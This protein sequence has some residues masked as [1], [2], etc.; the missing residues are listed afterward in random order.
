MALQ[1]IRV[2]QISGE[3]YEREGEHWP[4]HTLRQQ[5]SL[6][7]CST[8]Q[9]FLNSGKFLESKFRL[10]HMNEPSLSDAFVGIERA[11]KTSHLFLHALKS[12]SALCTERVHSFAVSPSLRP[13]FFP[14]PSHL[15]SASFTAKWPS[16]LS[17]FTELRL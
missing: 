16:P 14:F 5:M 11:H 8:S 1:Y 9:V 3:F 17:S 12:D 10:F 2:I 6:R 15:V 7:M 4:M 13:P